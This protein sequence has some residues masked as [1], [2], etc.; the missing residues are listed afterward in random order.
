M[1]DS[2]ND[3]LEHI[4]KVIKFMNEFSN[5]VKERGLYHDNSKLE[6]P[7]KE[8]F[9]EYTPKLKDC[10]YGSE[11]YKSYLKEMKVALNHHYKNNRHHAE[12]FENGI[13][14]MTLIDLIEMIAD[15]KAA[16]MRHND[17]DIMK[18]IEI[19]QNRFG[20]GDELRQILINTV[21]YYF[22]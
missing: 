15:W 12:F 11:E 4:Q 20:Y 2:R 17:G 16:S 13:H 8:I 22:K 21:E 6:S 1:Y 14:D 18:S 7:E 10:T 9:D 3:T 19:N 5:E